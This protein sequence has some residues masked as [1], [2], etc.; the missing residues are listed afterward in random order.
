MK[1]SP[2]FRK[3]GVLCLYVRLFASERKGHTP[4]E[5]ELTAAFERELENAKGKF[6]V[7]TYSSNIS[8][9][10][11]VIKAAQKYGRKVCFVGRSVLKVKEIAVELG[12]MKI[13]KGMEVSVRPA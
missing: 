3:E 6:I 10:N 12:Y 4:S 7:T 13:D 11:Q 9:L 5:S 8:R 1:K 2:K